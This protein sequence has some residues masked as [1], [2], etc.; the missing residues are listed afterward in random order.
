MIV[1]PLLLVGS[2][3]VLAVAQARRSAKPLPFGSVLGVGV[4]AGHTIMAHGLGGAAMLVG[5]LWLL[6][7]Q[8]SGLMFML[9]VSTWLSTDRNLFFAGPDPFERRCHEWVD[10]R[11]RPGLW[12]ASTICLLLGVAAWHVAREPQ[13]P[14]A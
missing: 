5:I 2:L 13:G 11:Y 14:V 1:W 7:V 6:V 10:A 8:G 12:R 9:M 3:T 4:M